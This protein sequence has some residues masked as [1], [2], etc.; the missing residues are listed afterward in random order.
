MRK[1]CKL[2]VVI[3]LGFYF[4]NF[5]AATN[6]AYSQWEVRNEKSSQ[7]IDHSQWQ[8][9]LATYVVTVDGNNLV[10]YSQVTPQD[11][12]E[13]KKYLSQLS[14][15][16]I[17]EYN[18]KEQLAYWINLYNASTINVILDHYP[19]KTIKD[20]R[21]S[22]FLHEGPW[23]AKLI[24]VENTPLSLNDIEHHIVRPIWHDPR[25][26]YALNCASMGCP[27][28]Q[29]TPYTGAE[30]NNMLNHAAVNFVNSPKGLAI[31]NQQLDVSKIYIWYKED[32]GNT[33][34]AVIKHLIYYAAAPLKV[35]LQHL[36]KIH[37]SFYNWSLNIA[38]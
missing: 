26:H 17:G 1:V 13:L 25:T 30:L 35:K 21:L 37:D 33:D 9:F 5:F 36:S 20:I 3:I 6:T 28:L 31:H 19:V 12:Q 16:P 18:A 27:N 4:C 11:R 23:D 22:G 8:K 2:L 10:K 32:F 34:Q 15:I 29:K 24:T 38:P 7:T 14:G